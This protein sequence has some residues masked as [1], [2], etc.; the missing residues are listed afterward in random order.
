ME[1]AAE[2][3]GPDGPSIT[4]IVD[5]AALRR[6][7]G[8]ERG[9]RDYS[10]MIEQLRHL[11][12]MNTRGRRAL[13]ETIEPELNRDIGIHVVPFDVGAYQA[14]KSPFELLEFEGEEE[15]NMAYF[16]HPGGDIVIREMCDETADYID[17]FHEM[18][19][20]VPTAAETGSLIDAI[21]RLMEE[22][23]NGVP[24]AA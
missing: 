11:K 19:N 20:S 13:G 24:A 2:L 16:E 21:I 22:G 3:T 9:E 23:R 14:L 6:G 4:Y 12:R 1:R 7:V 15:P 8:N 18:E 5:E 10:V 17:M